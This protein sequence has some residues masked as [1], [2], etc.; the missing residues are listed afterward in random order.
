MQISTV[1]KQIQGKYRIG[2]AKSNKNIGGN[3]SMSI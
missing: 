2:K 1:I 3:I